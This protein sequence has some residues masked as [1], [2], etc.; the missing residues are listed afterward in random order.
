MQYHDLG[1]DYIERRDDLINEVTL[2]RVQRVARRMLDPEKLTVVVVGKPE[3]V[4]PTADTPEIE[5]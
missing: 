4:T 2:T 1:I 3:R 5:I